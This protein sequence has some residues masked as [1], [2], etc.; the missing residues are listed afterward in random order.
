MKIGEQIGCNL[1]SIRDLRDSYQKQGIHQ[2]SKRKSGSKCE[3]TIAKYWK[4]PKYLS[5]VECLTNCIK[6][7]V[8]NTSQQRKWMKCK[9]CSNIDYLKRHTVQRKK[10]HKTECILGSISIN[11]KTQTNKLNLFWDAINVQL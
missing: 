6:V 3:F 8:W 2:N 11:F 9:Y 1:K 4:L 7:I 5:L 10:L